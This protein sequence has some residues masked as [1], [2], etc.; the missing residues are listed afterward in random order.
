MQIGRLTDNQFYVLDAVAADFGRAYL[1]SIRKYIEDQYGKD[2][3]F[4][5]QADIPLVNLSK[6]AG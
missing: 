1:A 4:G 6:L 3:S 5:R 2:M